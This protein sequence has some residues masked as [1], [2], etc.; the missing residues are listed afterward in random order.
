[1]SADGPGHFSHFLIFSVHYKADIPISDVMK[2]LTITTSIYCFSYFLLFSDIRIFSDNET[3]A[4]V[5]ILPIDAVLLHLFSTP[6]SHRPDLDMVQMR[7]KT[8]IHL[9]IKG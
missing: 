9:I 5:F 6:T 1:M 8:I 7:R 3:L 2:E 4:I